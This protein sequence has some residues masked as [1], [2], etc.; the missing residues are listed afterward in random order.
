MQTVTHQDT[1]T[2][3]GVGYESGDLPTFNAGSI[4]PVGDS[5]TMK[6]MGEVEKTK[7]NQAQTDNIC[8]NDHAVGISGDFKL[9]AGTVVPNIGDLITSDVA[10]SETEER[11]F[12]I[13]SDVETTGYSK[14]GKALMVKFDA[15]FWPEVDAAESA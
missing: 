5:C 15:E 14:G 11:I 12:V 8:T 4:V 1:P 9:R 13:V 6:E 2:Q 10:G 3:K 7:N